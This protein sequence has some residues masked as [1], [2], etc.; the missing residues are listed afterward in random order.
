MIKCRKCE[1]E[2][3]PQKKLAIGW[4]VFWV[5]V[6]WP[7]AILYVLTRSPNFCPRCKSNV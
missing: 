3:I 1:T 2:V 4:I 6:F 7:A 5:M